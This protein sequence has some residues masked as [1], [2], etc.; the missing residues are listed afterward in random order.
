VTEQGGD[1]EF[2]RQ[3]PYDGQPLAV[4]IYNNRLRTNIK[5]YSALAVL[6]PEAS[7]LDVLTSGYRLF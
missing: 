5:R 4:Q 6:R 7:Y 1:L 2:R 3:D